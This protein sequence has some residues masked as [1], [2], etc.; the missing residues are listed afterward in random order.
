M[1][2][3]KERAKARRNETHAKVSKLDAGKMAVTVL[4]PAGMGERASVHQIEM[5]LLKSLEKSSRNARTHPKKQI[6][7]IANSILRFGFINPIVV[8]SSNSDSS[9]TR[10][11]RSSRVDRLKD[12]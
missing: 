2:A 11:G 6:G 9:R 4:S 10:A 1:K 3:N 7:Q 8:D 5:V 12:P